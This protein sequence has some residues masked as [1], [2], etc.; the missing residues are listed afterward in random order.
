MNDKQQIALF[1]I[2]FKRYPFHFNI[3]I[4]NMCNFL[5]ID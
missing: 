2:E 5:L 3:E 4:E 1:N